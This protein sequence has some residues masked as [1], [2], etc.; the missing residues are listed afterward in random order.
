MYP[1]A[2]LRLHTFGRTKYRISDIVYS[3]LLWYELE[4][5]TNP[6]GEHT[7]S[8]RWASN[9]IA[10][11][12]WKNQKKKGY[13]Y[14]SRKINNIQSIPCDELHRHAGHCN[15]NYT[16]MQGGGSG[17]RV[18]NATSSQTDVRRGAYKP[19]R[20]ANS[21]N[22]S[23]EMTFS[24]GS[25][26]GPREAARSVTVQPRSARTSGT[27]SQAWASTTVKTFPAVARTNYN[28][29][30]AWGDD[31]SGIE[32]HID[33]AANNGGNLGDGQL[34][35]LDSRVHMTLAST[36]TRAWR[37]GTAATMGALIGATMSVIPVIVRLEGTR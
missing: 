26:N 16:Y 27:M 9:V 1:S 10:V 25:T 23:S 30:Q 11:P 34:G 8:H 28:A 19:R 21:V 2:T 13:T 7:S 5:Q 32:T 33:V 6:R 35:I 14:R 24:T 3:Q 20:T 18:S 15:C 12:T 31:K 37:C 22:S 17:R 29:S 4:T 36:P